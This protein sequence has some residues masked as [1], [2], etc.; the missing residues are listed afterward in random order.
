[1]IIVAIVRFPLTG[2]QANGGDMTTLSGNNAR[3][4]YSANETAIN[5][6]NAAN[7]K[8]HWTVKAGGHMTDQVLAA[9]G[10]LYWGSWDGVFHAS[11]PATGQDIWSQSLG[12]KP[13]SCGQTFG[14]VGSATVAVETF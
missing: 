5:S 6:S 9:N 10:K 1:M 13:G 3:T 7:L 11:N 14:I 8:L 4:G 12:T 2:V